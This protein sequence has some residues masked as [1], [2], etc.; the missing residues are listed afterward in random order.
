MTADPYTVLGVARD[1][2]PA[3]IATAYRRL[4]RRLHPDG[5]FPDPE[6][7]A[8]VLAAYRTLRAKAPRTTGSRGVAIPVRVHKRR[9]S[10]PYLRWRPGS[11]D[12]EKP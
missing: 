2:T 3:D 11:D 1:A 9:S 12:G 10:S 5:R 6:R 4:V 7:L 8:A